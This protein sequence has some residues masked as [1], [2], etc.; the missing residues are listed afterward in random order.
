MDARTKAAFHVSGPF[1]EMRQR[2][3]SDIAEYRR[4]L[5]GG[6]EAAWNAWASAQLRAMKNAPDLTARSLESADPATRLTAASLVAEYWP[7]NELFAAPCLRLAFEDPDPAIRGAALVSL[8]YKLHPLIDDASGVFQELRG[9]LWNLAPIPDELAHKVLREIDAAKARIRAVE[10]SDLKQLAGEQLAE[11]CD[12]C[13][14][15]AMYVEHPAPNLRR[16][17]IGVLY[18]YWRSDYDIRTV[19][20]RL[21][22][23]DRDT[24]VRVEAEETLAAVC[25]GTNDAEAGRFL[26]RIV[27]DASEPVKVRQ[28]AYLALFFVRPM[29]VRRML[30]VASREFRFPE[31]VDWDFVNSFIPDES[32]T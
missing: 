28:R 1:S 13:T 4:T 8:V 11:M 30:D 9:L 2:A 23:G 6:A 29:P 7:C 24:D 5:E 19:C 20:M 25:A 17:A 15:A 16:A 26:A 12:S 31:D 14:V 10:L 32:E 18:R 27:R 22:V 21:I 3:A